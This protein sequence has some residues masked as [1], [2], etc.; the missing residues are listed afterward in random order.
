[1]PAVATDVGGNGEVVVD[2]DTGFLVPPS[3]PELV[4]DK[5][6]ELLKDKH[7]RLKMGLKAKDHILT[8]FNKEKI[9]SE[10]DSFYNSIVY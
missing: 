10:Y 6:L 5:I 4:A 9:M 1:V 3:S 7:K 2:N 8:K